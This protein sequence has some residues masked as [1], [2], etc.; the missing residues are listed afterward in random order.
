MFDF[1]G[2]V[3]IVTGAAGPLGQAVAAAFAAEGATLAPVD[4]RA[5][6][7]ATLYPEWAA[8]GKHFLAE[9]VD[10]SSL[11]ASA[12]LADEILRRFGRIDVLVNAAG[13]WVGGQ[14]VSDAGLDVWDAAL[15]RNLYT[16]V[17]M[18]K[19][20]LP[21]MIQR[22]SGCIVNVG[23]RSALQGTA[24]NAAHAAAK[25][26][27]LRFTE[28][29]SAEVRGGGVRVNCVLPSTIDTPSNRAAMP[30][31]DPAKWSTPASVA[32]VILFLASPLAQ[33]VHG[34]AIPVFGRG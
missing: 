14:P 8:G 13:G 25:A 16:A 11:E 18:S 23:A 24:R 5:G 2:Q 21:A 29:L 7:L 1:A 27:V 19:A 12:A 34:A 28:S 10:A 22:Q 6:R 30:K 33:D 17:A 20:V 4:H 9:Q 15:R 32:G 26:A 3:V 31:A